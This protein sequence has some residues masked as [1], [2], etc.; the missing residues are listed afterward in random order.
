[1]QMLRKSILKEDDYRIFDRT[2]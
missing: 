1:M 2:M